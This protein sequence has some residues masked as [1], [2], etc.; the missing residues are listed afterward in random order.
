MSQ[1]YK[2]VGVGS[3][4]ENAPH[5]WSGQKGTFVDYKVRLE[6]QGNTVYTLTKKKDSQP[7]KVGDDFYADI[8]M[9]G[10]FGPKIKIDWNAT[11]PQGGGG[12]G[13]YRGGGRQDREP[14]KPD[15]ERQA[16]IKAEWA[17]G[18][19]IDSIG[20]EDLAKVEDLSRKLYVMVDKIKAVGKPVDSVDKSDDGFSS[21]P[22]NDG[23]N[24]TPANQPDDFG[25]VDNGF[26]GNEPINLDDIP[27]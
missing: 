25:N 22:A 16:D 23:F 26:P 20:V 21:A 14:F 18:K 24:S 5:E 4:G 3:S 11:R 1:Q 8:D 10:Q 6:G 27:F 12:G 19:V 7:P 17:I 15:P 9:S 2:V 13:S